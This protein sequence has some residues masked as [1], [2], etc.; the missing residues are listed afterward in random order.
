[1]MTFT[2]DV[3]ED[4]V[5]FFK[6]LMSEHGFATQEDFEIPEEHKEIVRERINSTA[7]SDYIAYEEARKSF[8][9]K[10]Q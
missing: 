9:F 10:D 3:P 8:R 1:M 2:I 5:E 7:E 6:E 4:R